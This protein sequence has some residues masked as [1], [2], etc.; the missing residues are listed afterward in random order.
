MTPQRADLIPHSSRAPQ[1]QQSLEPA[2]RSVLSVKCP[3]IDELG[4]LNSATLPSRF[5]GM[6][7]LSCSLHT[8]VP[9]HRDTCQEGRE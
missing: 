7:H 9:A 4:R 6:T 3:L 8:H 2:L 1:P 5:G